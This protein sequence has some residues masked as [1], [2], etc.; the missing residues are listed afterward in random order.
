MIDQAKDSAANEILGLTS[1]LKIVNR[2]FHAINQP[3]SAKSSSLWH[4]S[5][6]YK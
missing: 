5:A 4:F 3:R 2:R 6:N 1:A